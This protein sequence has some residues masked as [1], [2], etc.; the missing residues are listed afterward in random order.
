MNLRR[1]IYNLAAACVL[2][3]LGTGTVLA[4]TPPPEQ[5]RTLIESVE[6]RYERWVEG[7]ERMP[8]SENF[9]SAEADFGQQPAD[10]DP[11]TMG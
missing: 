10:I 3:S 2:L 11:G 4:Q 5:S 1:V 8:V 7:Y 9:Q 6:E